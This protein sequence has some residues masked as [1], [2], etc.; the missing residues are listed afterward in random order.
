VNGSVATARAPATIGN[1]AVGFDVLGFALSSLADEV[2]VSRD[3]TAQGVVIDQVDDME[4]ID[5]PGEPERNTASA[6]L[7]AMI[8]DLR[9]PI[10]FRV[11]LRKGIPVSAGL[12]G[13]AAS[14][15]GAVVAANVLLDQPLSRERLFPYAIEGEAAASGER[16]GD[17][18]APCLFG[19]LCAVVPGAPPGV[20]SIPVPDA[21]VCVVARPHVRVHTQ[22]ARQAL[23]PH[24][25]L[26]AYVRQSAH[27]AAFVAA[28]Y[29][30]DLP[31]MSRVMQDDLIGPQRAQFIPGFHEVHAAALGAGAIG[32][33]VAGSGPSVFAWASSQQAADAVGR[34]MT[35]GFT[36]NG[37]AVDTVVEPLGRDGATIVDWPH[38]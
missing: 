7:L 22:E 32:C 25:P 23:S 2:T 16:H 34:A 27:L 5:L 35:E 38:E 10:G 33:A 29:R 6:A 9:L 30:D 14:A 20:V 36:A 24:V 26:A 18:V 1:V 21:I 13:S 12:G 11:A 28:C 15:V 37:V 3:D 31:L 4:G 19:G 8:A 17:N